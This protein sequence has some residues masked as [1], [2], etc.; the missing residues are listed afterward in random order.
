MT[1]KID[2]DYAHYVHE[3][4]QKLGP[5]NKVFSTIVYIMAAYCENDEDG[6]AILNSLKEVL[7][8]ILEKH[9]S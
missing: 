5:P 6:L 3:E 4:L 9:L 8:T 7:D 2:I 1:E